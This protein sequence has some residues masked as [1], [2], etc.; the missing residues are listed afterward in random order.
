MGSPKQILQFQGMSLLS[1][2]AIAAL[3]AGSH[4][5]IVVTGANADLTRRELEGLAV[6]EVLNTDWETGI[7]SSIRAGIDGLISAHADVDAAVV[8]LCDQPHVTADVISGL[9]AARRTTRSRIV[10]SLYGDSFGV[11][12]LFGKEFFAE[13][14]RLEGTAG[15]KQ[16]IKRH[17]SKAHFLPFSSGDVDVD[18]PEDFARLTAGQ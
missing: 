12:A 6:T 17:A 8:M 13:L 4:P 14:A 3:D 9:I 5:V 10:A 15:A 2:A 1:R 16:V 18:T 7:A 11:P